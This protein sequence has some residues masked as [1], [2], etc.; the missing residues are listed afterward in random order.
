V[1]FETIVSHA[2]K[3]VD[4]AYGAMSMPIYQTS[5]FVFDDIGKT[6]GGYDYSRTANPTRKVL[7]DT[8]ARLEGG[9]S[10]FAF[11]TG[12]AAVTTA[13]HL[14]QTGDHVI[15]GVFSDSFIAVPPGKLYKTSTVHI[16]YFVD[17]I[18]QLY[19]CC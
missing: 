14:L 16:V 4:S 18:S 13:I 2:G 11:A 15:S 12:M 7:E 17:N 10:G 3:R 6:R 8:L 9:H 5:D 1:E 19:P